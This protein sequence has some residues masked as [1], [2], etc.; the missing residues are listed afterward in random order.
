MLSK[1]FAHIFPAV[2]REPSC[3][4]SCDCNNLIFIYLFIFLNQETI[5]FHRGSAFSEIVGNEP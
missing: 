2:H 5:N 1:F 4:T 3:I